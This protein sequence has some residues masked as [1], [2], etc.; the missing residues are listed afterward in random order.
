MEDSGKGQDKPLTHC[1]LCA[2]HMPEG[3]LIRHRRT[4]CCDNNIQMRWRRR[5]VAIAARCLEAKFNLTGEDEAE[6][7][8]GVEVFK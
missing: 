3:N 6:L 2:M 7:I 5:D 8:E 4:T 1:D